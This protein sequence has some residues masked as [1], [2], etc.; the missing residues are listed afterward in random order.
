MMSEHYTHLSEESA[1]ETAAA[2]PRLLPAAGGEGRTIEAEAIE[3]TKA[4]PVPAWVLARLREMT[5]HNWE[6]VRDEL[7]K[8]G[9]AR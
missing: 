7:T 5:S 6:H 8:Q 1:L 2:F 3:P 9:G 4:E